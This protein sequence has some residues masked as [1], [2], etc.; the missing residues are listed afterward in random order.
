MDGL[1]HPDNCAAGGSAQ[2]RHRGA[3][4]SPPVEVVWLAGNHFL[5]F[6]VLDKARKEELQELFI[7]NERRSTDP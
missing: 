3:A 7:Q 4:L 6:K 2:P 5:Y 1:I